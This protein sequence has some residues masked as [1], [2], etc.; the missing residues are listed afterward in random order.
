MNG[1][2]HPHGLL[3]S[4]VIFIIHVA[5]LVVFDLERQPPVAGDVQAPEPVAIA[6]QLVR[7]P[8]GKGTQLL[9]ILHV[10]QEGQHGAELVHGI[11][12]QP[13]ELSSR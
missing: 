8:P 7:L 2:Q 13:F 6:S 9:R 11:G 1:V 3:L 5:Y 4:V 10:L 12:G